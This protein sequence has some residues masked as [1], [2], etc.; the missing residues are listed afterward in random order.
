MR[1]MGIMGVR[2]LGSWV[3]ETLG[4]MGVRNP[5]CPK[6]WVSETLTQ[7]EFCRRRNISLASFR[8]QFYKSRSSKPSPS[9][10]VR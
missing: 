7:P 3:S 5:G 6:P 9:V 2:N 8:Y 1:Y 4:I 10:S